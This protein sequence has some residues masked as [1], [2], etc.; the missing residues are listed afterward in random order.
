MTEST[1]KIE[2]STEALPSFPDLGSVCA[3]PL[4]HREVGTTQY[5]QQRGLQGGRGFLSPGVAQG[6]PRVGGLRKSADDAEG[7]VGQE[8]G[9]TSEWW[10]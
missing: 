9:G 8:V 3:S 1:L 5:K 4:H 10:A 6:S 7:L 2:E